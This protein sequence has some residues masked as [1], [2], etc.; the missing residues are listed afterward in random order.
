MRRGR[1]ILVI[2]GGGDS[3]SPSS[4]MIRGGEMN[5]AGIVEGALGA[6]ASPRTI[7]ESKVIFLRENR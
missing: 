5:L 4:A 7:E 2:K 6:C 3:E 1:F